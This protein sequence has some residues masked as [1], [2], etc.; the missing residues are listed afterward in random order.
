MEAWT[1]G[2]F[3]DACPVHVHRYSDMHDASLAHAPCVNPHACTHLGLQRYRMQ[4]AQQR[5]FAL[6]AAIAVPL[7]AT[8]TSACAATTCERHRPLLLRVTA[9][10][11][12]VLVPPRG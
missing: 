11:V 8:S 4:H 12:L 5:G 1:P 2:M 6:A 10:L 7:R 3:T 9:A